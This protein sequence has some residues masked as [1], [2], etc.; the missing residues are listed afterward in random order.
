MFIHQGGDPFTSCLSLQGGKAQVWSSDH[1]S[2]KRNHFLNP[3]LEETTSLCNHFICIVDRGYFY[4]Q[5][6]NIWVKIFSVVATDSKNSNWISLDGGEKTVPF[7]CE[8]NLSLVITKM[9]LFRDKMWQKVNA[10]LQNSAFEYRTLQ[11][12]QCSKK[13]WLT[14]FQ[15]VEHFF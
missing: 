14:T 3:Q 2:P 15:N 8:T 4:S 12:S 1:I 6:F 9:Y 5:V 13:F 7:S 11:S 10:S